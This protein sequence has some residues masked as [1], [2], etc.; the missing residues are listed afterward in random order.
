MNLKVR[1]ETMTDLVNSV[2]ATDIIL[3]DSSNHPELKKKAS[4]LHLISIAFFYVCAGPYG[5]EE[6]IGAGGA[7]LAF[8][9]TIVV[10]IVYS[11][12]LALT[13]SELASRMPACGGAVEWG[14]VL[15]K[16]MSWVNSYIRFSCSLFDNATYPVMVFDYLNAII[17][18]MNLWYWRLTVS[19]LANVFAVVCNL[20]G[21][22]IVGWTSFAL[23]F[24]ILSPFALFVGFGAEF[25]TVDRVF[26][27]YP[28]EMG[29]PK[30]GLLLSALIWQFSGFDTVA[31]LSDEVSNPRRN[32]PMGMFLTVLMVMI[33][34]LLPT[35]VGVSREPDLEQW[36]SGS[37]STVARELP[38]CSNGWLSFWIS[39]AGA[40]SSLSLLNVAL[41]CTGRELY[42]GANLDSFPFSSFLRKMHLNFRDDPAPIRSIVMMSLFTLPF[43]LFD[44]S[45]LV[46][47]SGLL[48]VI[49]Q[50][51]QIAIFTLCRFPC[52]LERLKSK[53]D[54]SLAGYTAMGIVEADERK[55]SDKFLIGWGWIGVI[56]CEVPLFLIS[57]LLCV[58]EGW[59]SFLI[60]AAIITALFTLKGFEVGVIWIIRKIKPGRWAHMNGPMMTSREPN[61]QIV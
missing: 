59:Q 11:L 48:T 2:A 25:M 12:P 50:F 3:P 57:I 43:S 53:E 29:E 20:L 42:A 7:R 21:L 23:C 17:P 30:L 36:E 5:Q 8:I 54:Q 34:Y 9:A 18:G 31:A 22:D 10:A 55:L 44:F 1:I 38:Y 26:A 14:Q 33:V 41:S 61:V 24:V 46:E 47:W 60:V 32:F 52:Y 49:S 6:V 51:I 28:K 45:W 40:C 56:L 13:S 4:L 16:F 19:I 27:P 35:I 58:L 39:L 15:G 37:W